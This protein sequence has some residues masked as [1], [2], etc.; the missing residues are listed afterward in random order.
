MK[1]LLILL[2][3]P[4]VLTGCSFGGSKTQTTNNQPVVNPVVNQEVETVSEQK[5]KVSKQ[6]LKDC[7]VGMVLFQYPEVWGD[8]KLTNEE[9]ISFRTNYAPYQVDLEL[10]LGRIKQDE[11]NRNKELAINSIKL[12]RDNGDFYDFAQV[13]SM[14]GGVLNLN[15][16]YYSF[17]FDIK[18]N[19]P[20]PKNLDGVLLPDN[21]VG[22]EN[23]LAIMRSAKAVK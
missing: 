8:C 4:L 14:M 13:G 23:L 18:S 15:G 16:E 21:N 22:T 7:N 9:K 1:K 3:L 17:N 12:V 20:K 11:Y 5:L 10:G 6:K 19:Q 2:S